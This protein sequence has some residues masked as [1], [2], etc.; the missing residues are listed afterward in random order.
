MK[1]ICYYITLTIIWVIVILFLALILV[2]LNISGTPPIYGFN[3]KLGGA[4][5]HPQLWLISLGVV[6]LLRKIIYRVLFR[7][8]KEYSTATGIACIVFGTLW[9]GFSITMKIISEN[10]QRE[11]IELYEKGKK[12]Q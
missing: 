7:Q 1:K 3:A 8:T 12:Y 6:L 10:T 2:V 9:L 4:C 11:V 5:A